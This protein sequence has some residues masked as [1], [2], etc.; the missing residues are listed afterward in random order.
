MIT[1]YTSI[2]R[3]VV[4]NENGNKVPMIITD[5]GEHGMS[6]DELMIWGSLHWNFLSKQDL[7][8]EYLRRKEAA[9]IS[10][11]VSF[12]RTLERLKQRNLVKEGTDYIAAD[13]L[14]NLLSKLTI[15]PVIIS[16][17]DKLKSCIYM[18]FCKNVPVV[19]CIK[20]Y[21]GQNISSEEKRILNLAKSVAVTTSEIIRCTENNIKKLKNEEDVI[22]KIY[23]FND[24]TSDTIIID[25]RFSTVKSDVLKTVANLY[26]KKRIIF[27]N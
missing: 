3:M 6:I 10:D 4:K 17:A 23:A 18:C 20:K 25:T 8:K 22:D 11:D 26:L 19:Q 1:Y 9:H 21:F 16:T 13:A 24:D 14:Y 7:E 2:G 27:E 5:S 12:E 15:R